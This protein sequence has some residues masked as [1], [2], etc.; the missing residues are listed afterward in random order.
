[1][2]IKKY[3]AAT[4]EEALASARK[5]LGDDCILM[6]SKNVKKGGLFSFLK[7]PLVEITV[8]KEE[9]SDRQAGKAAREAKEAKEAESL[10]EKVA[11]V[12][13]VRQKAEEDGTFEKKASETKPV[14][15]EAAV[16]NMEKKL[17]DIQSLL[18]KKFLNNAAPAEKKEEAGEKEAETRKTGFSEGES[19]LRV[20]Y[21][22]LIANEVTEDVANRVVSEADTAVADDEQLEHVISGIYQKIILKF[23]RSECINPASKGAKVVFLIGPTGAGKTTTLAKLASNLSVT[24]GKAVAMLTADTYRIAA[25]EQLRTYAS[26]LGSPFEVIYSPEELLESCRKFKASDYI[27]VDTAGHSHKNDEQR[28]LTE[29]LINTVRAEFET[30]V[31]LVL[32]A[33]TKLKDLLSAADA[34]TGM[35]DVRLLFTKLDE[36]DCL[37]NL[38]NLRMHTMAP[39]SYVTAGQDVPGDIEAFNAQE[40]VKKILGGN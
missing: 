10:K 6:H 19:L 9:E 35:G 8:A 21:N 4:E 25:A 5:E 7:K 37:G 26:I 3:T 23:G 2:I 20:L 14:I 1:M 29:D 15:K 13:R 40:T 27:F 28:K 34:Y 11:A 36:T 16:E 24:E 18:E 38:L 31:Y 17:D 30:E 33:S 32:S 39:M 22:K 12:D